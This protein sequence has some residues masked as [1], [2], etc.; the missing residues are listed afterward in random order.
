VLRTI[1]L[2][3]KLGREFG[4]LHRLQVDSPA[5]AVRALT[6]QFPAMEARIR[7]GRYAVTVG[8]SWVPGKCAAMTEESLE[9][10][11]GGQTDIHIA[12]KGIVAGVETIILIGVLAVV[13]VA[14]LAT[15]LLMRA[16]KAEDREE[17]TKRASFIFDGAENVIEQGHPVQLVYGEMRV[18][19][20]VG[21]SGIV[22]ADYA[23]DPNNP[24][25]GKTR[26]G[27]GDDDDGPSGT[28]GATT[29]VSPTQSPQTFEEEVEMETDLVVYGGGGG[30]KGGSGETPTE[31]PNDLQST[32]TARVLEIIGEGEVVGLV[33]G[34]KSV[35][36]DDTVLQN[37][38]GSFNFQ[39]VTV[40]QRVGLPDQDYIQGFGQA[41][42][43]INVNT[44]VQVL[45]GAVTRT[46][47]NPDAGMARVTIRVPALMKT[48]TST[49]DITGTE[50]QVKISVQV[51][52]G[53]FTDVYT[54][55]IKGKTNSGYERSVQ[56]VLPPGLLRDIRVT[57][58]T[59][60]SEVSSLQNDTYWSILTEV[61][62]AKFSYPDTAM[63]AL[64]VDARQ[65][66]TNIP[67]RSYLIRGLIIEVP[68]NYD[69]VTRVYTGAWDG[70]FKRAWTDNPA[71][72][73][74]DLITKNR[75]GLGDRVPASAV[76]K[77][78]L[79]SIAQYCDEL[80]P[81]GLGGT[82]PRFTLNACINNPVGAF[83]LLASIASN[84]RGLVYW[85][86][87]TVICTQ[88]RP[89]DPSI[90]LTPS[91]VIDGRF[92][93]GRLT[94]HDKR[95]SVAVVYWNDPEDGHKLTPEIV[96][97]PDLIRRFGR[98]VGQEVTGFGITNRG[99]AHRF[100][101]WILEDESPGSNASVAY[102]VG[103][104]HA[105][106]AP[107][108]VATVADPKFTA[109]RRGG[110]V[111]ASAANSVTIDRAF[112]FL[113]GQAYGL[114][115]MLP[116]GTVR[117]RN[118]TNAA[119]L[120]TVVTLGGAAFAA[121]PN[122]GAVWAL[123]S[124][125]V[126]NRQFRIRAIETD[127]P[128]YAVKAVL[129]DP[130]KFARVEQDIDL[131]TPAYFSLP[132]GP[133]GVPFDL[134]AT[135]FLLADGTASIPCALFGWTPADDPRVRF[136]QAQYRP[137]NGEWV[138][139]E[140]SSE[141]SRTVRNIAAGDYEF[142]VRAVDALGRRTAWQVGT[143]TM[144]GY[145]DEMPEVVA[146]GVVVNEDLF[147]VKLTW[148][149]PVDTRPLR[150]EIMFDASGVYANA[151]SVGVTDRLEYTIT[152]PG[153][154]WVRTKFISVVSPAPAALLVSP[155]VFSA[156]IVPHLTNEAFVVP[157]DADGVVSSYS[158]ATGSVVIMSGSTDISSSF[159]LS[160]PAGG[161]PQALTVNYV[162]R[163]YTVTGGLDAAENTGTL[164]I[165]AT[166]SGTYAGVVLDKVFTLGKARQGVTGRY[167]DLKF[168]RS[169]APPATPTGDSPAGWSDAVP[170][171]SD[172]LYISTADKNANGTLI[173]AWSVPRLLTARNPRGAYNAA[174]T[175]YQ[176]DEVTFGS[177][178]STYIATQNGF[179]NHPPSGTGQPNAYW[180]VVA[181]QGDPGEPA[182]PPS[183]FSATIDV[184]AGSG[185]NLRTL[186]DANGYTGLSNATVV[187]EVENAI[188]A[189]GLTGGYGVDSGLW[190]HTTYTVSIELKVKN[191]GKIHGGSGAGGAGGDGLNG[192]SGGAGGDA[193]YC[194][195]PM[196]VTVDAGGEV[197]S[198]GGGGGGGGGWA[199][200]QGPPGEQELVTG[201][202]GN[203][204]NGAN[205]S[206]NSTAADDSGK[207]FQA[208]SGGV[209]GAQGA[210]GSNGGTATSTGTNHVGGTGGPAGYAIRKNGNVV[211][212]T[213]NGT[214]T[215]TQG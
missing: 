88:D 81:D 184:P 30:G 115:V 47:T 180:D 70:T 149:E 15:V 54:M 167:R 182:T 4:K 194:R 71:W 90:L 12:P 89:T 105:F 98:R 178:V 132:S 72:I 28:V 190:P 5:E 160:T 76:D 14:S 211:T 111:R 163:T 213:N 205:G 126:A 16:P 59:D 198:G 38:D 1:R 159:T 3:G 195:L 206:G 119:G 171:G 122:P 210:A 166:G 31:A 124:D 107:G 56:L 96:E 188:I 150:Y 50:V 65:F 57:R 67:A 114:R 148:F 153:T 106:V 203:G 63:I 140:D 44:Q 201:V 187:F 64:T 170:A 156:G 169:V 94:P 130:T 197:K 208:G 151:V 192:T 164:V 100:A 174:T 92:N 27:S 131:E 84:F 82:Q 109:S 61:V 45:T 113:A 142:R 134:G 52:G 138:A 37:P 215:G 183:A 58:L 20:I 11:L 23:A 74:R 118:V 199:K 177:P 146:P 104:D 212:V 87:G 173:G 161:N 110:R 214:I 41:E 48:D 191:G 68:T 97:D 196:T 108:G 117:L 19:S 116:D 53:G 176:F 6:S 120:A 46:V 43:S 36:F 8:N 200:L 62:E 179:V 60:D 128:P 91:N 2:H 39:G 143:A 127:E 209:G 155:L 103:E 129:H 73:L 141:T 29:G 112:N 69:P 13:A 204:G 86:T 33:N 139:L 207:S 162:G 93:Y 9:L 80:V 168:K 136:F 77:W 175:Y 172:A 202:G 10:R 21:S 137:A 51:D 133:L 157:A 17:A 85:G 25:G 42:N 135:E 7:Q 193:I 83:D 145:A 66:G 18:G 32:A 181:G 78:G 95:R 152:E 26:F 24:P 55:K 154:Y 40:E 186:A 102:G 125:A 144:D 121:N 185:V 22:T 49:G 189:R 165:R 147:A 99:Q 35:W 79:Y 34:M 123:E 101:K 158:G 75:Y